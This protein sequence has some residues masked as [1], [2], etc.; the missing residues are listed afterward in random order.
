MTEH[1][2]ENGQNVSKNNE[3]EQGK[4]RLSIM[5]DLYVDLLGSLVPG[6]LTVILGSGA[7]LL[8]FSTIHSAYLSSLHLLVVHLEI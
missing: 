8:A 1:N 2:T 4:R 5:H 6:L 3:N 7:V